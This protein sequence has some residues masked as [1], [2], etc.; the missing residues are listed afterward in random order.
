M[1]ATFDFKLQLELTARSDGKADYLYTSSAEEVISHFFAKDIHR[2]I[3]KE[4]TCKT[5]KRLLLL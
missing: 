1:K 5:N 2:P 4:G 3:E